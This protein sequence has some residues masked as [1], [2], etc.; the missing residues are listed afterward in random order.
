[1]YLHTFDSVIKRRR[2][3]N[4][5]QQKATLELLRPKQTPTSSEAVV[6]LKVYLEFKVFSFCVNSLI[7]ANLF[8]SLQY[9][10]RFDR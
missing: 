8:I 1:M 5:H 7:I 3:N 2:L 10:Y 4:H 9:V 6:G